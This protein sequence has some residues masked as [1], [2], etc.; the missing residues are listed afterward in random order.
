MSDVPVLGRHFRSVQESKQSGWYGILDR[1]PRH[2]A[3]ARGRDAPVL[4]VLVAGAITSPLSPGV[5]ASTAETSAI[6]VRSTQ[7]CPTRTVARIIMASMDRT[8]AGYH[9]SSA[10][11][12]HGRAMSRRRHQLI[13]LPP[14]ATNSSFDQSFEDD[15]RRKSAPFQDH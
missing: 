14:G 13:G 10:L 12:S 5:S 2:V 1:C 4:V 6:A 15:E 7:P 8:A 3:K 11:V 9:P